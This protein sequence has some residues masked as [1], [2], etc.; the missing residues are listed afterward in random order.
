MQ[1]VADV[2]RDVSHPFC[3]EAADDFK[4]ASHERV[5]RVHLV[6][7]VDYVSEVGG[8]LDAELGG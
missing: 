5:G 6:H 3:D 7:H 8:G 4:I 1:G 2:I